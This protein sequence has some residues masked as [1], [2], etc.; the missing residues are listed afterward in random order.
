MPDTK[1]EMETLVV[2]ELPK[3]PTRVASDGEKE[4]NLI[5]TDE[6]H[7]EMLKILRK[8]EKSLA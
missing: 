1:Q 8:L 2:S 6:A 4:Y 7:T 3:I 5:T